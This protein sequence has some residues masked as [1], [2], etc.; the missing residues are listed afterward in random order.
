MEEYEFNQS[1]IDE[2]YLYLKETRLVELRKTITEKEEEIE[3]LKEKIKIKLKIVK[4]RQALIDHYEPERGDKIDEAM[5]AYFNQPG[6][7]VPIQRLSPGEYMFGT[8]RI[9]CKASTKYPEG[10]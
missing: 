10:F 7:R 4:E 1:K 2:E 9:S 6:E 5:A 8:Y 3:L